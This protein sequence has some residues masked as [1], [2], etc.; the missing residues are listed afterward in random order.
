MFALTYSDRTPAAVRDPFL[1]GAAILHGPDSVVCC[2]CT[3][4][5]LFTPLL[6]ALLCLQ[7]DREVTINTKAIQKVLYCFV[8]EVFKYKV[9]WSRI[10]IYRAQTDLRCLPGHHSSHPRSKDIF[11][12]RFRQ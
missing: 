9:P 4:S 6:R 7:L 1:A 3:P 12:P 5:T 10:C 11:R 2:M 8:N